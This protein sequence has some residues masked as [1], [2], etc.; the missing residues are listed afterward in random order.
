FDEAALDE[1]AASIRSYGIVQ[2]IVVHP[3]TNTPGHYAIL[4]GERRWRAAQRAGL[5]DVPV[6]VRDTDASE[7]LELALVENLQRAELTPIEE[8][9]AYQGILDLNGYTQAE[10]AGRV[11]KDRSTVANALRLLRLP[12]RVQDMLQDGRL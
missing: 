7:R 5:H 8:A 4:A 10:L 11:G 9:R 2:P 6:V 1:L 12:E 3:V